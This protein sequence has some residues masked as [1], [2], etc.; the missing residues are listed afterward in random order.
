MELKNNISHV[1]KSFKRNEHIDMREFFSTC[2]KENHADSL[3]SLILKSDCEVF[4]LDFEGIVVVDISFFRRMKHLS[5]ENG[6][7]IK[8]VNLS[9]MFRKYI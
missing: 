7:K 5:E 3:N 4:V 2:I 6:Y 9:D 1:I 8:Y